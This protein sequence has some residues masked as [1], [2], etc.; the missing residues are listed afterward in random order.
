MATI[1]D[2]VEILHQF[3]PGQRVVVTQQIPQ[4]DEV[5]ITKIE[6]IVQRY[7]QQKT[8]SWFAATKDGKLWLDRLTLQKD[9][10]EI[11]V[12]VLDDYSRVEVLKASQS[13]PSE[14]P[15]ESDEIDPADPSDS[16]PATV[17]ESGPQPKDPQAKDYENQSVQL[18]NPT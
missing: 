8:G 4:R 11:V 12:C 15:A 9:D 14:T 1:P 10:G 17:P 18:G 16:E 7:D 3:K 5:W 13:D 6:G 2:M